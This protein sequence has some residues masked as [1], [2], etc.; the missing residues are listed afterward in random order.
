[1]R[2]EEGY[3]LDF[4]A[5]L[6]RF[7][8]PEELNNVVAQ[9]SCTPRF[10]YGALMLPTVLKYFLD[11]PQSSKVDMV[12]ARLPGYGLYNFSGNSLPAIVPSLDEN[13]IVEGM[14]I[15]GL[16]TKQQNKIFEFESGDGEQLRLTD[17]R[18][19]VYQKQVM[20]RYEM[21]CEQ[22]LDAGTY[23]WNSH[24]KGLERLKSTYWPLGNFLQDQ[25]YR[26]LVQNQ[27]GV[28]EEEQGE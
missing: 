23:V 26:N 15:F 19:Q 22:T 11:L 3:P 20:G 16:D 2:W 8:S 13:S 4:K 17:V 5:V 14:L 12:Y 25:L 27:N 28:Q 6:E 9:N 21:K 1:M 18:V 10:V 7:P 24:T